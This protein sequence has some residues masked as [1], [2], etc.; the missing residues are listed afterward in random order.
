MLE[1]LLGFGSFLAEGQIEDLVLFEGVA[2]GEELLH[3]TGLV[4]RQ[5]QLNDIV[6]GEVPELVMGKLVCVNGHCFFLGQYGSAGA[7][8][9][10]GQEQCNQ[11]FHSGD[12]SN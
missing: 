8:Q 1:I 4:V 5:G 6:A 12:S 9:R 10:E 11:L 3:F 7:E 2:F